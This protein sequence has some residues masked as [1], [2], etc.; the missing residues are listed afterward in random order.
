MKHP[1][2]YRKATFNDLP[3]IIELLAEDELGATREVV[4]TTPNLKYIEAFHK[5]DE[6]PHHYLMVVEEAGSV[7]AT[8]HLTLLPSL[9]MKGSTRLQ[10]EAVRVQA[11]H[12]SQGIGE[13]MFQK[14]FE[15]AKTHEV[16]IL[17][18]TTNKKRSR[19][20][21]FYERLG[22]KAS[23]EGMKQVFKK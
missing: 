14:I 10:I 17:Q 5:I 11:S 4:G 20:K 18:L 22:F 15:F 13:A 1:L 3:K 8:C 7:I 23:H 2:A 12:R 9:T 6:D 16:S 21:Q 19:A